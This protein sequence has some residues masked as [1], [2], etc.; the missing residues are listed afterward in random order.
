M[1]L[2]KCSHPFCPFCLTFWVLWEYSKIDYFYSKGKGGVGLSVIPEGVFKL[3]IC[4]KMKN[5]KGEPMK[6]KPATGVCPD[7]ASL[8]SG[9]R[10]GYEILQLLETGLGPAWRVS[11]SSN[12][13]RS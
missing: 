5:K 2:S 8:M 4:G 7:G 3:T 10:H 11:T 9:P 12:S 13:M 6:D 1:A